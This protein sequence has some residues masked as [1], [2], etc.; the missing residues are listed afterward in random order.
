MKTVM[1]ELD[2]FRAQLE[3]ALAETDRGGVVVT[4]NG[5]PWI[6]LHQVNENWDAESAALAQS[7]EFWEMIRQRRSEAAIP[8][9]EAKRRLGV[10]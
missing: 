10:D 5:K 8:W 9:E 6:V 2:Q 7:A 4:R 3:E 1:I